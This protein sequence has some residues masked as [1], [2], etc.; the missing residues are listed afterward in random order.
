MANLSETLDNRLS[1][2]RKRLR[3]PDMSEIFTNQFKSIIEIFDRV[4][5]TKKKNVN[6]QK[7]VF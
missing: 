1:M 5:T 7:Y 6:A 3:D 4:E 2:L